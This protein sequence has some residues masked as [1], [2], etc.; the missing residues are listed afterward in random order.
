MIGRSN[1]RNICMIG[2]WTYLCFHKMRRFILV[3]NTLL[4]SSHR[5]TKLSNMQFIETQRHKRKLIRNGYLYVCQKPLANGATS[6]ECVKRKGSKNNPGYCNAK[7]KLSAVDAFIEAVNEHSHP[8]SQTQCEVAMVKAGIKRRAENSNDTTQQ[9]LAGELVGV[10]EGAAANL[11]SIQNIRRTIRSQKHNN[12][13]LPPLPT[14]RDAIPILP[15]D[16]QTSLS[17]Q[18]FLLHDSGVGDA[19]RV[20]MFGSPDAVSL[21]EQSPHWFCDGTFK[22]VPELFYQLYTVHAKVGT[23]IFPCIYALLPNKTQATYGHL[24]QELFSITN[25]A[26]PTSVLMD[27]EKAALNAFEA[28]HPNSDVIGC[29]FH[30][31]KNI[32]R[33]VQSAGLQQRYQDDDEFSVHVRMIMALAF[34]P[35]ADLDAAFDDLFTEIRNN[36]NNDMDEVLNY[37]EDTYIGRLRRGRRDNPMFSQEML[38]MY[39][40]TRDHLPRTNNNVEGWHRGIQSHINACHPNIWKFLN[41]IKKEENLTR[42]RIT[43][44]LGGHQFPERKKYKDVNT[45]IVNIVQSYPRLQNLD[46]LRRIAHNLLQK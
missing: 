40:R 44:V 22:V 15:I 25:N 8:P 3:S 32:W 1:R 17:G 39:T 13:N 6:G 34:V 19:N 43:Q 12:D 42:V 29:F 2:Q 5:I 26:S 14:S 35:L 30:L 27:F 16:F 36:Y 18:Q 7:V 4:I 28:I 24:F 46:Y 45:R 23:G 20:F 38:N 31:S 41:V 33:K 9:V 10:S 11:P 37:F 21:L